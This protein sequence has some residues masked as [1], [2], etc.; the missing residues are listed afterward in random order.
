V[1]GK[2][3]TSEELA[4]SW[5]GQT[6]AGT[7]TRTLQENHVH[8][9]I[10]DDVK[11]SWNTSS[12]NVTCTATG[13]CSA[14]Q[15]EV[16]ED[17]TIEITNQAN[18]TCTE[19]GSTTYKATFTKSFE[20]KTETVDTPALGHDYSVVTYTWAEGAATCTATIKCSRC[21]EVATT[22]T[23]TAEKT[24]EAEAT[25]TEQGTA[26][27]TAQFSDSR[28]AAQTKD[29]VTAEAKGHDYGAWVQTKEATDSEP[30]EKMR[31]C[32]NCDSTE[33]AEIPAGYAISAIATDGGLQLA[34]VISGTPSN[35]SNITWEY[36][37]GAASVEGEEPPSI[38]SVD[39]AGKVTFNST[40]I[41][42][43]NAYVDGI[44]VATTKVLSKASDGAIK[45]VPTTVIATDKDGN[46][47]TVTANIPT[48]GEGQDEISLVV[49]PKNIDL[50]AGAASLGNVVKIGDAL[51][52]SL[53]ITD[54]TGTTS[55]LV[56][57]ESVTLTVSVELTDEDKARIIKGTHKLVII[58]E[59]ANGLEFPEVT[60][61]LDEDTDTNTVPV[62]F[63]TNHFSNFY[64]AL[65]GEDPT[66][67]VEASSTVT[68]T[69]APAAV[70]TA[71]TDAAVASGDTLAKTGDGFGVLA[72]AFASMA[73]IA[74]VLLGA[75]ALR[76][77]KARL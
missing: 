64:V 74:V 22:E 77:R 24:S 10:S 45:T 9:F 5:D 76:R 57:G 40:G 42:T 73:A 69:I 29:V 18:A 8:S 58:H 66:P 23:V 48:L 13:T 59:A 14:C 12:T 51:D 39:N 68:D 32:A 75:L 3:Y 63:T 49:T 70:V 72:G 6:M 28:L 2:K 25:C 4:N 47:V 71:T 27:Y 43:V 56:S 11:Y 16:C 54:E 38:I 60:Y 21:D 15:T 7:Y 41:A 30:G 62:T 53:A 36:A 19:Q 33:T 46:K 31:K 20:S 65:V 52:I 67:A 34:L 50:P 1:S 37:E 44:K 55:K 17:A 61:D 26:T 35:D